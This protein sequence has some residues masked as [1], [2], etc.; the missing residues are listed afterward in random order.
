MQQG[1]LEDRA[2]LQETTAFEFGHRFVN[3]LLLVE[4]FQGQS[5]NQSDREQEPSEEDEKA[6]DIDIPFASCIW[7]P[8]IEHLTPYLALPHPTQ[9][10]RCDRHSKRKSFVFS[11]P[12]VF[13]TCRHSTDIHA[14]GST[15][16]PDKSQYHDTKWPR[17]GL[18]VVNAPV[19]EGS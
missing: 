9:S 2:V 15:T 18:G 6:E 5:S 4:D 12:E 1:A 7:I 17:V 3:Q 14:N 16:Y 8:L 13:R 11:S 10:E 19:R